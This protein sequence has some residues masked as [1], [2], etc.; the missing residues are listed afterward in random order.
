[1]LCDCVV[2][3]CSSLCF[4][5]AFFL[6]RKISIFTLFTLSSAISKN[7]LKHNFQTQRPQTQSN[8]ISKQ[9]SYTTTA[10]HNLKPTIVNTIKQTDTNHD[11]HDIGLRGGQRCDESSG[12]RCQGENEHTNGRRTCECTREHVVHVLEDCKTM[13]S[14]LLTTEF[15]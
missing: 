3:I 4:F 15:S 14:S 13:A 5:V 6:E 10:K 1:M 11:L 12:T 8:T 9:R 2:F 7:D